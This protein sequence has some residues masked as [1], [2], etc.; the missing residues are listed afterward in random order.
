MKLLLCFVGLNC[1]VLRHLARFR[2]LKV[3]SERALSRTLN[4][5]VCVARGINP[6]KNQKK[7][8]RCSPSGAEAARLVTAAGSALVQNTMLR[9][10][11]QALPV[12]SQRA[13]DA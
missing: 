8:R 2:M 4:F 13:R 1:K 11:V 9:I 7:P 5:T 3:P 6:R 10:S 12:R